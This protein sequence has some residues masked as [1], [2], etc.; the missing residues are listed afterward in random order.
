M[1]RRNLSFPNV[2]GMREGA[3]GALARGAGQIAYPVAD[4]FRLCDDLDA[5]HTVIDAQEGVLSRLV[6]A[7]RQAVDKL[8]DAIRLAVDGDVDNL[9]ERLPELQA[10]A[11]D[12]KAAIPDDYEEPGLVN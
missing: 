9:A 7:A 6:P 2:S 1:T 10:L 3:R 4:V 12:L 5:V 11:G 8:D